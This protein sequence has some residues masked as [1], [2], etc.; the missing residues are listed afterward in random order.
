MIISPSISE[1]VLEVINRPSIRARHG[2]SGEE[3]EMFFRGLHL[4][5]VVTPDDMETSEVEDDP[6]DDKFLACA[7]E[8]A[9][10]Y[11]ISGDPHLLDIES[12]QEIPIL[13][14]RQF[15]DTFFPRKPKTD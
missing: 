4:F 5:A 2:W 15:L 6:D 10:D 11:I 9:A 1:E 8:G 3:I 7:V 14:P 12:Y 13:T